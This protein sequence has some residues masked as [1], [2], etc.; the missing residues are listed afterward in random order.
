MQIKD[1]LLFS[2]LILGSISQ[3]Q[4]DTSRIISGIITASGEGPLIGASVTIYGTSKGTST[5]AEGRFSLEVPKKEHLKLL[6]SYTGTPKIVK[7][8]TKKT[9]YKI[10]VFLPTPTH[11]IHLRSGAIWPLNQSTSIGYTLGVQYFYR[12][13]LSP[14]F[15]I[16]T[17]LEYNLSQFN[18]EDTSFG[19]WKAL[20]KIAYQFHTYRIG[21]GS[22]IQQVIH[23][24]QALSDKNQVFSFLGVEFAKTIHQRFHI[25]LTSELSTFKNAQQTT[26][27]L[28]TML[29]IELNL[30]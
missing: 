30:N 5:D 18:T 15:S 26:T 13:H 3:A 10:D 23:S 9:Y 8:K 28:A 2:L 29:F 14:N 11:N 25:G 12:K 4:S 6:I 17:G 1:L 19:R 21:I 24:N 7:I 20:L 27:A 22:G 16:G